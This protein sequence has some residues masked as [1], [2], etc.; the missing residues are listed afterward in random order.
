MVSK[1]D[2]TIFNK[3]VSLDLIDQFSPVVHIYTDGSKAFDKGAT[4]CI[5][6]GMG[7]KIVE[8]KQGHLVSSP[9]FHRLPM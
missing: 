2:V 4:D 9:A 1:K 6:P 5:F 7:L 8:S 3:V